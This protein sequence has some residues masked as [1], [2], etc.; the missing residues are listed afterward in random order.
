MLKT[1]LRVLEKG[2]QAYK[3]MEAVCAILNA[4]CKTDTKYWVGETWFDYG[5]GWRWTTII[6]SRQTQILYPSEWEAI[7]KALTVADLA[8][9]TENIRNG[10]YFRE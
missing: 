6:N 9:I 3:N 2:E 5:Q 7:E 1:S 8:F 10:K 4:L